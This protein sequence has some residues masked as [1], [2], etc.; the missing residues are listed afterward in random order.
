MLKHI[1]ARSLLLL[2]LVALAACGS[3]QPTVDVEAEVQTAIAATATAQ[4]TM[5]AAIEQAVAA[6][7]TAM[8]TPT[9]LPPEE[10]E[11][12]SE[13]ELAAMIDEAV[14]EAIVASETTSDA[15][16]SAAA[17]GSVSEDEVEELYAYAAE[18]EAAIYYAEAL[19]DVYMEIYG[20]Y[21]DEIEVLL[22][23]TII[24]LDSMNTL[25]VTVNDILVQGADAETLLA[26]ADELAAA[27]QESQALLETFLPQV[28]AV[29]QA[30]ETYYTSLTPQE[31]AGDRAEAIRQLHDY[32]SAVQNALADNR[33][34]AEE[35]LAIAQLGA[36]AQASLQ[37]AGGPRLQG[38]GPSLEAITRQL[39]RGEWPQARSSLQGFEAS[40][41]S[42]PARP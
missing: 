19:M 27:A 3:Q 4:A 5:Q 16:S 20:I 17:D 6:T 1:P 25:L 31:V 9:P 29:L 38:L 36:N 10:Y 21:G 14:A 30:R 35:M 15:A 26:L 37:A 28:E 32:A 12:V 39:A 22:Q 8:P 23:E 41:P 40:L 7:V 13:E 34:T 24:L 42:L 11:T 2:L 18:A 33:L